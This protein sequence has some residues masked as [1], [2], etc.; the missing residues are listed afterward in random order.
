M[1]VLGI[2]LLVLFCIVALLLLFLI[3]IQ[4]Q[5]SVGLGS[6]FGGNSDSAFG[7]GTA[8]FLTKATATLAVI[9]MVLSL[10]VAL[11]NKSSDDEIQNMIK[12]QQTTQVEGTT[13]LENNSAS[14]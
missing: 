13:W 6:V 10:V 1:G 4:G 12:S 11:V 3:A 9:F 7:S 14:N 8:N 2:I 5:D